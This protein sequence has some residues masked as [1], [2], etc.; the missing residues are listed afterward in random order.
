[1]ACA[2]LA[3]PVLAEPSQDP[4]SPAAPLSRKVRPGDRLTVTT[5]SSDRIRG[6]LVTL[7]DDVL[8]LSTESGEHSVPFGTIDRVSRRRHGFLL[9]PIIGAGVGVGF[10]I[11]VSMI[12]H[13]EGADATNASAFLIGLGAG[14]GLLIDA[15][16]DLPRTVYRRG[17]PP[18]V[19]VAPQ[20]GRDR[21]GLTMQVRF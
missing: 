20:I 6:T 12:F 21:R 15:A 13:N 8:V 2:A 4:D 14:V 7:S 9:G 5:A 3:A 1:M 16:V 19:T 18:R 11:P 10:A 17:P